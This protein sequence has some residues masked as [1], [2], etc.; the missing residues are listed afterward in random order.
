MLLLDGHDSHISAEFINYC[1]QKNIIALCLPAHS[2]HRLQPL[3]VGFNAVYS[4]QYHNA[5]DRAIRNSITGIDKQLFIKLLAEA[6]ENTV[7]EDLI[8]A[9][10]RGTGLIPYNPEKVLSK[11]QYNEVA[12]FETLNSINATTATPA[13]PQSV[14]KTIDKILTQA[15]YLLSSP[16][17]NYIHQLGR[18]TERAMSETIILQETNTQLRT[19]NKKV[20]QNR[21]GKPRLTGARVL[22][23]QEISEL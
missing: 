14:H 7:S 20:S 17:I 22:N 13:R 19:A 1:A 10:W 16:T 15:G 8:K 4:K 3:D 6:R 9:A 12:Q 11:L 18:A 23:D 5:A 2:T 21:R